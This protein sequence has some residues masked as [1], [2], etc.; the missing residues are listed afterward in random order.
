[1]TK[2]KLVPKEF[3]HPHVQFRS[4]FPVTGVDVVN[5]DGHREPVFFGAV[6]DEL[7]EEGVWERGNVGFI[8]MR[9]GSAELLQEGDENG[10]VM[11]VFGDEWVPPGV[12][13]LRVSPARP[14]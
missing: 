3:E 11:F 8:S 6:Y 4:V 14:A 9:W 2:R 1:M 10:T 12:S 13:G 5:A 7:N